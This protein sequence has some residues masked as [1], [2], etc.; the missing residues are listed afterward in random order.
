[1]R[2]LRFKPVFFA[3]VI[4]CAALHFP[5]A[6]FEARASSTPLPPVGEAAMTRGSALAV[7]LPLAQLFK[8]SAQDGAANDNY[9]YSIAADG[10]TVVVG[11][12]LETVGNNVRQG[13][14][15][16]YVRSGGGWTLQQKLTANDGDAEDQFGAS[17][18]INGATIVIGAPNDKTG[19]NPNQGSAY[20][21]A[22]SGGVW[23]FQRKL[24]AND[25]EANDR[26]GASVAVSDDTVVAGAFSD[27]I[28]TKPDQGSAYVFVR[29]GGAWALQQKLTADDGGANDQLGASVAISDDTIIAG[30]LLDDLGTAQ[31][32]GSAYVFVRSGAGWTQRQKL[33]GLNSVGA[34]SGDLFGAAVAISGDTAIIGAPLADLFGRVNQGLAA[35]FVR[36]GGLWSYQGSLTANDGEAEDRFGASV[37]L[38]GD[39]AL[40][41]ANFDDIGAAAG[42]VLD[43]GSAYLFTRS[44]AGWAPRQR[45]TALGGVARE[46]FGNAVA[47]GADTAFVGAPHAKVGSNESQGALYIFG[48]GYA[49]RQVFN[50]LFGAAGDGFG[51]PVAVDGDTAVVGSPGNGVVYVFVR[52]VAGWAYSASLY[53]KDRA[54]GDGFGASVAISGDTV[55]IG[56][57]HKDLPNSPNHGSIYCFVRS[58]GNWTQQGQ[59]FGG[60]SDDYLGWSVAIAGGLIA[61]GAPYDDVNENMDQGSIYLYTRS[62]ATL[63]EE[64]TLRASDSAPLGRFGWSVALSGERMLVGAPGPSDGARSN[65]AAYV[66]ERSSAQSPPWAQRAKLIADDGQAGDNLGDTV[67]LSGNTALVSASGK[68][69]NDPPRR[70]AA[71]VFV[72]PGASG[73]G[74][75]QQARLILGEGSVNYSLSVAI[76]GDTAVVGTSRESV[77]GRADQGTARVFTRNGAVWT[78]R[79]QLLAGDGEADDRFGSAVAIS[80]DSIMVGATY[81]GDVDQGAVYV[82]KANCGASVSPFAIVS[83]ASF[84]A[85]GLP[86]ES[87]VAGFGSNLATGVQAAP[88][89]PLPTT[90]A[91]VSVKIRDSADRERLAPLFFVSPGQINFL[92]P[93]GMAN[94]QAVLTVMRDDGPVASGETQIA[95]VS[96]GLFSADA[97]GLGAASA[98]ALRVK[99]DGSQSFEPVAKYDPARNRFAPAPIDLGP[100]TDQIFLVFYG[101]G[102]RFRN[103][104][105]TVNCTI[106][107][108]SSETLYAGVVPGFVGLDQVNVRLP[109]S[110]AGRGEVDVA[111][112]VD[113]KAANTVRVSVR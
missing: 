18:A 100:T 84:A 112:V 71:Y 98:V 81:G 104:L 21:F 88:S 94:G 57:P 90:L 14:A 67:A 62:G 33:S 51:Y 19:M 52:G 108:A 24:T 17:A 27:D 45:L 74:W 40:V 11:A 87:I 93:G 34:R 28:G 61:V 47:L 43:Q 107:G 2:S 60:A 77:D 80:G 32:A 68:I 22:R 25:G 12:N 82:L 99:A 69:L 101:S 64:G 26:F 41:G 83:A 54:M 48:C 75:S 38:N 13:S 85:G 95:N 58:G 30:A 97:S 92:I 16:V 44:G 96:P 35:V 50:G 109:R 10:D 89:T 110:L 1:M 23:S 42:V 53:A 29:S 59:A 8:R 20:V 86:P 7:N 105:S 56:A 79:Q 9:G 102:L 111:L 78:P 6:N 65:G 31:D 37:A 106:G 4:I 15:Y 73:G 39:T 72:G 103:S 70:Q 36:S 3:I 49:E 66:F 76:S 113:G 5:R 55:V 63:R 46:L 91:G